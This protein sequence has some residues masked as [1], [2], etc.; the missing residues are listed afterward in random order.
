MK[1]IALHLS[2]PLQSWGGFVAGDD[3]PSLDVPTKS[4]VLGLVAGSLGIDRCDVSAIHALHDRLA[5]AIRV[6][7]R[8]PLEVDFQTIEGA[9]TRSE[10]GGV[11]CRKGLTLSSRQYLHDTAFT[12][13][14]VEVDEGKPSLDEIA[15]GL[16]YPRWLPF[17]GRRACVP[18]E[19]ILVRDQARNRGPIIEGDNVRALFDVTPPSILSSKGRGRRRAQDLPRP[20]LHV[21][22]RLVPDAVGYPRRV[23][24]GVFPRGVRLFS[25][26][27]VVRIPAQMGLDSTA[28][29]STNT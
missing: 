1:A 18:S 23:R 9:P 16:R 3:R 14:L 15:D 12:V 28:R 25:E 21:E 10:R 4:G 27:V 13:L 22:Q 5:M 20:D 24:D 7:Y 8:G 11:E 17:L 6:D 2:G 29:S 26:R 19:P